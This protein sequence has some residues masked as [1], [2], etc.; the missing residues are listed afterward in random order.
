[1]ANY[2]CTK[3][4]GPAPTPN[5]S[6]YGLDFGE[7]MGDVELPDL[8]GLC[9]DCAKTG[10]NL[11]DYESGEAAEMLIRENWSGSCP[12][13]REETLHQSCR[14]DLSDPEEWCPACVSQA[15]EELEQIQKDR[16]PKSERGTV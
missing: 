3:C 10:Q 15:I 14:V 8:P 7:P 5:Q 2:I 9:L 4:A 1:M 16:T 13:E 12:W 6:N 11:V